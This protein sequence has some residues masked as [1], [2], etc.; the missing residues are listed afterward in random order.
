MQKLTWRRYCI[1]GISD[2]SVNSLSQKIHFQQQLSFIKNHLQA[3]LV[4]ISQ[5]D[6]KYLLDIFH[7]GFWETIEEAKEALEGGA[8]INE[9]NED[10]EW[11][12]FNQ[13]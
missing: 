7:R 2:G 6:S 5:S 4:L 13:N 10:G 9:K 12:N 8:D 11:V 3:W 1:I